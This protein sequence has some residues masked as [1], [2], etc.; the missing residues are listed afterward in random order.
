VNKLR[1]VTLEFLRH[2]PAHNQ[3]L[4]PLTE[5]LALCGNHPTATVH[6][7]FEH[8]QL[9]VR[10]GALQYKDSPVTRELQL[11]DTAQVM[12]GVL[13]EV[14]GLIAELAELPGGEVPLTH[15]RLILSS[16]E[17]ALMPFELANAPQGFPGS[18]QPLT[19][20]AQAP[21]CLT[22]EV[23]RESKLRFCWPA[24]PRI[25]FAAA[26]PPGLPPV[27]LEAHLLALRK[28]ID[29]WVR[30]G[31][32]G[33]AAGLRDRIKPHLVVLPQAT[34]GAIE[35]ACA[36]AEFSHVHILAHGV[37]LP[38]E[39]EHYGLA[40]HSDLDPDGRDVVDGARLATL[41]HTYRKRGSN[42][43]SGPAVVSI[44]SCEGGA[45]GSVVGAGS[46]VAHA[47]HEAG[48]PL[49]VGAQFPLSFAAS[50]L[51]VEDLYGGLLWGEDPRRLLSKLRWNLRAKLP[52][53]HDWASL[54]AYA[55]L[56]PNLS[57]QLAA[58]RFQQARRSSNVALQFM[59]QVPSTLS[60]QRHAAEG[61]GA[62]TAEGEALIARA[63]QRMTD[64]KQ[65]LDD[66]LRDRHTPSNRA[67]IHGQLALIDTRYASVLF[68]AHTFCVPCTGGA[69]PDYHGQI[70]QALA[71]ARRAYVRAFAAD[72]RHVWA[73]VR[74]LSLNAVLDGPAALNK[75]AWTTA[76]ELSERAR[77]RLGAGGG[78]VRRAGREPSDWDWDPFRD[79]VGFA[80]WAHANLIE[81]YLLALL[82]PLDV[83]AAQAEALAK[84][85]TEE[86]VRM[87]P[88]S[89]EVYL[90]RQQIERYTNLFQFR[91]MPELN[92]LAELAEKLL[93]IVPLNSR[94]V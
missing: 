68:S 81:L 58:V 27:P 80:V 18:A 90:T 8:N 66:L 63:R 38:G 79:K 20:Q 64:A 17:L 94:F 87:A 25:L 71:S 2:G 34:V 42:T 48:I 22:R 82:P 72:C 56:P 39:E 33:A 55:A 9:L 61:G 78:R 85:Y 24:R 15:L 43:L 89:F 69:A 13:S 30:P 32:A 19:L 84:R 52:D 12:A 3:L 60:A 93:R 37:R 77:F 54:V 88:D 1:T 45:Q 31:A 49:V 86:L 75:D 57:A 92:P 5:Y 91:G 59:D 50:V 14:P 65:M 10:L 67:L 44:A 4:S 35:D 29:P 36:G 7:P 76:R 6:M 11:K 74:E 28:V 23:R 41:L 62:D 83:P 21:V 46:S 26:A 40:L 16:S 47:L 51:L 53:T 70:A 73:L